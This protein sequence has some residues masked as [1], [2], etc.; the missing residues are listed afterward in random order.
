V[1]D[2]ERPERL[3]D[4][5][6]A[7]AAAGAVAT[8]WPSKP[9]TPAHSLR[10]LAGVLRRLHALMRT[11]TPETWSAMAPNRSW[12]AGTK[13]AS[14]SWT[15]PPHRPAWLFPSVRNRPHGLLSRLRLRPHTMARLDPAPRHLWSCIRYPPTSASHPASPPQ[16]TNWTSA[17]AHCEPATSQPAGEQSPEPYRRSWN[18]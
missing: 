2:D 13:P 12:S 7:T 11:L 6:N 15:R 18:L 8:F 16:P 17:Y 3:S 1:S 14:A 9:T 5:A 10:D 4:S